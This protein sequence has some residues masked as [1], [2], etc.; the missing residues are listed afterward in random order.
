MDKFMQVAIE[1]ARKASE[2]GEVPIGAVIERN[3]EII[4]V[5]HNLRE[6]VKDPTAHAEIIAIR[7]AANKLQG[8]RL[9]DCNLYVTVEPC[10]MCCS[11][12]IQARLSKVIF[13]IRE[14]KTGAIVSRLDL[15][16]I[17]GVNLS[18]EEGLLG[19]QSRE[20]MNEFFN[21]IR[22]K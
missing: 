21:K 7:R 1:Q 20:L 8:W 11:A 13:S 22:S 10:S 6:T 18:F 9:L 14:P 19:D 4:S 2:L 3:N 12:I 15:P 5:A 16:G 17:L